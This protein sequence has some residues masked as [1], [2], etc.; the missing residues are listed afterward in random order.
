MDVGKGGSGSPPRPAPKRRHGL[1]ER[2]PDLHRRPGRASPALTRPASLADKTEGLD[3]REQLLK[4]R[5]ETRLAGEKYMASLRDSKLLVPGFNDEER[6]Q[7]LGV[8]H[9]VYMHMMMQSCLKP[10]SRGVNANSIIQ[11]VG[12]VMTMRMLAPDFKK[13]MDSY[14]QPLKDKIQERIDTRTRGMIASAESGIAHRQRIFKDV[15]SDARR[16]RLIGSTDPRDHL[17]KKWRKRFDAMQHRERG[18]REMFTP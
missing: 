16:E 7:E 17:T 8:M 1:P 5:A 6:T 9:H 4:L 3:Q 2:L 11:A 10:L 15:P 12:M 13:E 14:L 18:H